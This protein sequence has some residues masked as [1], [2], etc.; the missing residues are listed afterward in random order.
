MKQKLVLFISIILSILC[1]G[2]T[3]VEIYEEGVCLERVLSDIYW[4]ALRDEE[5]YNHLVDS[6]LAE[7]RNYVFN[8]QLPKMDPNSVETADTLLRWLKVS[9]LLLPRGERREVA[10]RVQSIALARE[11]KNERYMAALE[12]ELNSWGYEIGF[13]LP[14]ETYHT[15]TLQRLEAIIDELIEYHRAHSRP[16]GDFI[17][18]VRNKTVVLCKGKYYDEFIPLNQSEDWGGMVRLSSY[19]GLGTLWRE[20]AKWDSISE[21]EYR[22]LCDTIEFFDSGDYY[23]YP[24]DYMSYHWEP[25]QAATYFRSLSLLDYVDIC[26]ANEQ[27]IKRIN[28][29][30]SDQYVSAAEKYQEALVY[31][32]PVYAMQHGGQRDTMQYIERAYA[33]CEQILKSGVLK[34]NSD[35]YYQWLCEDYY[36]RLYLYGPSKALSKMIET[37]LKNI[38]QNSFMRKY[39]FKLQVDHALLDNDYKRAERIVQKEWRTCLLPSEEDENYYRVLGEVV[40]PCAVAGVQT[41]LLQGKYD[42][43]CL[44]MRALLN[45][46]MGMPM[47]EEEPA[48]NL[49]EEMYNYCY[50]SSYNDHPYTL[51]L[52]QRFENQLFV[53]CGYR[54]KYKH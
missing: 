53:W 47:D 33:I 30:R 7:V 2:K 51:P 50:F 15:D 19:H 45:K 11:G 32:A 29:E 22:F 31:A 37:A 43:A 23:S 21:K 14:L 4:D 44:F 16:T 18:L 39:F 17:D 49:A 3:P 26:Q 24:E 20:L 54:P 10:R 9:Y 1:Y 38:D 42:V 12:W 35:T 48:V 28:G 6:C 52:Q 46:M 41:Y 5:A 13:T 8:E 25:I 34:K 27:I 36:C 40:K